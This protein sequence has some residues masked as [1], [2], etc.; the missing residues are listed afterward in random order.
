[1]FGKIKQFF[2]EVKIELK[3]VTFPSRDE[4]VGSTKVVVVLVIIIAVFLGLI[5]MLLSK[6][7]GMLVQ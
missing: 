7:I 3:K 2:K 1:V 6:L 5:D 4:V